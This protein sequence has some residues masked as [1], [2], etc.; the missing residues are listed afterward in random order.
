[1]VLWEKDICDQCGISP[2]VKDNVLRDQ[3]HEWLSDARGKRHDEHWGSVKENLKTATTR[4]F[5]THEHFDALLAGDRS[6]ATRLFQDLC[7]KI[8]KPPIPDMISVDI[9]LLL[10]VTGSVTPHCE[11]TLS[12]LESSF[13]G[14]SSILVK[15]KAQFPDTEVKLHLGVGNEKAVNGFKIISSVEWRTNIDW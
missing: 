7:S 14:S 6:L 2:G 12:T 8:N 9:A 4:D 15:M 1:M 3:R 11:P 5:A 10:D 13:N